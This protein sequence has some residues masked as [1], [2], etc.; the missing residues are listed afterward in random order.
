MTIS[1]W[2][3]RQT[4]A[5]KSLLGQGSEA[6][7]QDNLDLAQ[8]AITEAAIILDM[9]P[10][11]N[12]GPTNE[13]RARAFN[14]L[15]VVYQRRG[16][17]QASLNFHNQAAALCRVIIEQGNEDF[18]SNSAATHLNFASVALS[19]EAFEAAREAAD[20]A[21]SSV[22]TL[23]EKGEDGALGMAVAAYQMYGALNAQEDRLDESDAALTKS[24]E[25][26]RKAF[27]DGNRS[28]IMQ[29][30]QG[31]QQASVLF[32]QKEAFDQALKWGREAE[33]LSKEAFDIFGQDVVQ[34]YIVSQINLI[35]YNEQLANYADSEDSLWKA[36]ELVGDDPRLLK[37][38][39]DFYEHCRK[40]SNKRLEEGNLPREEVEDGYQDVLE[41]IEAIGGLPEELLEAPQQS[42][43]APQQLTDS[44]KQITD[45]SEE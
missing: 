6:L 40:Q 45:D 9:S 43:P 16:D 35:S 21:I 10:I 29:A 7:R 23:L 3:E 8:A 36:I 26:T 4:E 17:V 33:V 27:E 37:R 19:V 39:Q 31:C 30:V 44:S 28:I 24:M 38:G 14:E 42:A 22:D 18:L 11:E 34:S 32:F 1:P 2:I 5:T 25:L 12:H 41:R 13:L 15:G 20:I